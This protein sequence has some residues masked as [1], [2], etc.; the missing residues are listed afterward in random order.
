[1]ADEK[2]AA[3]DPARAGT[4]DGG[5]A[6]RAIF[7]AD[8]AVGAG[9]IAACEKLERSVAEVADIEDASV[10]PEAAVARDRHET[11]SGG[12]VSD[13]AASRTDLAAI[14]DDDR[15][16][17]QPANTDAVG[18]VPERACAVDIDRTL[19]PCAV[20]E[21]RR[22]AFDRASSLDIQ[23]SVAG[24]RTRHVGAVAADEQGAGGPGRTAA[25]DRD[26]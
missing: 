26:R 9:Q 10:F 15:A 8:I 25:T 20:A 12:F 4:V 13:K 2:V 5:L 7:R 1:M 21:N 16:C 19:R 6:V 3:H 17:A 24:I 14:G 23:R 11:G 18:E 22:C